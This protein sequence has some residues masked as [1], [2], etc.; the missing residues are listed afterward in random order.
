MTHNAPPVLE[1][2][3][4]TDETAGAYNPHEPPPAEWLAQQRAAL[5]NSI[6]LHERVLANLQKKLRELEL[7]GEI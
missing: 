2:G 5:E 3:L 4:K 7:D 1:P 6:A